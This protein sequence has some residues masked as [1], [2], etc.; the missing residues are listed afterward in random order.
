MC[1]DSSLRRAASSC[2]AVLFD[3]RT[4]ALLFWAMLFESK[5]TQ[6][7]TWDGVLL[8]TDLDLN[9]VR[10][11]PRPDFHFDRTS[12]STGFNFDLD[13]TSTSTGLRR[14]GLRPGWTSTGFDFDLAPGS[15]STGVVLGWVVFQPGR[16]LCFL[17]RQLIL[18]RGGFN[19][20]GFNQGD[21]SNLVPFQ[22]R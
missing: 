5:A 13:R 18:D 15:T 9:R 17:T 14:V 21:F 6:P 4:T 2:L 19:P 7:W 10:L 1:D 12:T 20:G 8:G 11:R 3:H 16:D 22:P